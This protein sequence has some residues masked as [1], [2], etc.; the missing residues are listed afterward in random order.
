LNAYF[1]VRHSGG[2]QRRQNFFVKEIRDRIAKNGS[3]I[4]AAYFCAKAR[5]YFLLKMKVS[6]T[7][8]IAFG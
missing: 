1:N 4:S 3:L 2:D 6:S 5:I 7:N 8:Q